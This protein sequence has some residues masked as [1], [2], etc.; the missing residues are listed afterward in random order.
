LNIFFAK[1]LIRVVAIFSA[2]PVTSSTLPNM[3]PRQI[4]KATDPIVLPTPFSIDLS[5]SSGLSPSKRP[6]IIETIN[7]DKK[8]T[9]FFN[10]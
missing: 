8:W 3:A 6:A 2:A 4:I 9:Y 5:K 7:K 10:G 1:F